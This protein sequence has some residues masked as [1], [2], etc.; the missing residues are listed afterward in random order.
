MRA[1]LKLSQKATLLICALLVCEIGFLAV[2]YVTLEQTERE[3]ERAVHAKNMAAGFNQIVKHLVNAGAKLYA[4]NSTGL[5]KFNDQF[6]VYLDMIPREVVTLR[7]LLAHDPRRMAGFKRFDISIQ[8]GLMLLT[9]ARRLTEYGDRKE[10][11]DALKKMEPL[12][13]DLSSQMEEMTGDLRPEIEVADTRQRAYR[14]EVKRFLVIGVAMNI[15]LAALVAV[16]LHRSTIRRF[17]V[18]IENTHRFAHG[19]KLNE[20]LSGGDEIGQLD[21]VFHDMTEAIAAS[22]AQKREFMAMITHDL[23]SPLTSVRAS[24]EMMR[25]GAYDI[26]FGAKG[27]Q[28]IRGVE[29]NL[30][31]LIGLIN[32]LLDVEKLEAGQMD[33]KFQDVPVDYIIDQAVSALRD[34]AAASQVEL[35]APSCDLE[36]YGDDG[37]LVQVLV[38]LVA[39]AIKYS[40]ADSQVIIGCEPGETGWLKFTVSDQGPGIADDKRALVFERF[41]QVEGPSERKAGSSGLGLAIC[42]NI[43][44]QH[45]GAIAVTGRPAGQGSG[46]VFWFTVPAS[47]APQAS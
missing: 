13:T 44:E 33:M 15:I 24:M 10:A 14:Q 39:N 45:G 16:L 27:E 29:G 12:V 42:K 8:R 19:Q 31:R 26:N 23:R 41:K 9:E 25:I 1:A 46:S 6:D 22:A 17:N 38:N 34:I 18:L 3:V 43:V 40:P 21:G 35:V 36:C 47:Q 2:L 4:Y 32:D 28:V 7:E 30:D 11:A 20:R 5:D 37:R